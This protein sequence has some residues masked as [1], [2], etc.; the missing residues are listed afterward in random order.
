MFL[1]RAIGMEEHQVPQLVI[2]VLAI[3]VRPLDF[4]FALDH[5]PTTWAAPMLWS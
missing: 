5:L 4:L 3:P 1:P 2:L